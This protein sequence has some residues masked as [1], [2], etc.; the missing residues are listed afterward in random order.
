MSTFLSGIDTLLSR[1]GSWLSGKR[2]GLV[3]HR[4]A[5][6]LRGTLTAQRLHD[7]PRIHLTCLMGPEH[8][9]FGLAGAGELC[10]STLHPDWHIPVFS[11]YG[12]TRK[13]TP[14]MLKHFDAIVFDIQDLG[15]RCYTYVS[16]LRYI[17]E[18]AAG[19]GKQV[20]VTDRPIP[21]PGITD[22]PLTERRF[23]SFVAM[24]PAPMSYGMTPGETA[25]WLK[26][27]LE[28]DLDLRIARMDGY[29][30]QPERGADW[31]RFIRPSPAITSWESAT[32]FPA[33]VFCEALPALDCGR[34]TRRPF[35]SIGAT[36]L[37]GRDF[38]AFMRELKLPGVTFAAHRYNSRPTEKKPV[39]LEG[40]RLTVTDRS[41]F[42]PILTAVSTIHGLQE[43]YGRKKVW[44]AKGT[45]PEWFDKLFGTDT[46]RLA[47]LDGE[48]GKTIAAR[49]AKDLTQF[50]MSRRKCLL[51]KAAI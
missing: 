20:I 18:V 47:L 13:P 26:D 21:L 22:G 12:A 19:A 28:L 42:R 8:G 16:T 2:I 25:L 33:T 3:S 38:A 4:A 40:I 30:R 44:N 7:D 14:A 41:L 10:A 9:F 31:P 35:Q 34:K 5:T 46:V 37:N 1:H 43:L 51:Y 39:N 48:D 32:C 50:N 49:W 36:W 17:L 29:R 45:R 11:L 23:S 24:I 6:D 27:T 15:T